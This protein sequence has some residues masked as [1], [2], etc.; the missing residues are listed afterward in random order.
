MVIDERIGA[1]E[2]ALSAH[3]L[4][5]SAVEDQSH[6][7]TALLTEIRDDVRAQRGRLDRLLEAAAQA[8][9]L[10]G[11]ALARVIDAI[12]HRLLL[13]LLLAIAGLLARLGIQL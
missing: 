11:T 10:V 4:R 7:I 8:L 3:E 1:V 12:G 2:D 13:A 9:L 6:L 5:I